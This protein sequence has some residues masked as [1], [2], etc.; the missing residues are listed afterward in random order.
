MQIKYLKQC[1]T[2]NILKNFIKCYFE[3]LM[4]GNIRYM[5]DKSINQLSRI[6]RLLIS[7]VSYLFRK[8]LKRFL[9]NEEI[10]IKEVSN[11][12]ILKYKIRILKYHSYCERNIKF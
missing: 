10:I 5:Y 11:L 9:L 3:S 2:K 8:K 1:V 4:N 7:L 6:S 12:Y